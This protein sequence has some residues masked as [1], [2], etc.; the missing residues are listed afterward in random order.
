[1]KPV[2]NTRK[3]IVQVS[4]QSLTIGQA[5][6][7]AIAEVKHDVDQALAPDLEVGAIVKAVYLELWLLGDGQQPNTSVVIVEKLISGALAANSGQMAELHTYPN[8]NNIFELHQGLVGDANA[9][10]T[11]FY[12]NW[13]KIPKGKQRFSLGDSLRFT[14]RS[15]TE[16]MQFCG[17]AIFKSQT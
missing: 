3:H 2:I 12:R 17:V 8:K 10:P 1:M 11:P 16:G 7:T 6:T 15:N 13:I 4:L 5:T 9:N 14:I